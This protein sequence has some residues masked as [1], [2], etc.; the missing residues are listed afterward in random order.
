MRL[1]SIK[2]TQPFWRSFHL[3]R[4]CSAMGSLNNSKIIANHKGSKYRA[5]V[6]DLAFLHFEV[7]DGEEFPLR[8][9]G[10]V[11]ESQG[12]RDGQGASVGSSWNAARSQL[13]NVTYVTFI[14]HVINFTLCLGLDLLVCFGAS[15]GITGLVEVWL[16]KRQFGHGA[17]AAMVDVGLGND[18]S[19]GRVWKIE[20][21]GHQCWPAT[22]PGNL[23]WWFARADG[24]TSTLTIYTFILGTSLNIEMFCSKAAPPPP[25]SAGPK[26]RLGVAPV[27]PKGL[28][29]N[30]CAEA[31]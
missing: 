7:Q 22:S 23:A 28:E 13:S 24:W 3:Q 14:I 4:N 10:T 18:G 11:L 16:E 29:K 5:W 21:R 2:L 26:I 31:L 15:Q 6:I 25:R 8:S 1:A 27:I 30:H 17:S 20:A 19:G 9:P 12:C